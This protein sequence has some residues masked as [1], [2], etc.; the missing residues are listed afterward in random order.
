MS[1]LIPWFTVF[2]VTQQVTERER[3]RERKKERERERERDRERE[4]DRQRERA[5]SSLIYFS[6][7]N[8]KAY[9]R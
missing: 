3:E 5:T 2:V 6:V 1:M 4:T 9:N 7:K 8:N